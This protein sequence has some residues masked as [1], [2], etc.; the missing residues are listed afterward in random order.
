MEKR[1]I[2]ITGDSGR[3]KSTLASNLSKK[4]NIKHYSTD[5]FLWKK[6]Y[7]EMEDKKLAEDNIGKVYKE[8]EWIVEGGS[9]RMLK[10]SL[11]SADVIVYLGFNNILMQYLVLFRRS[12]KRKNENIKTF[13]ELIRHITYKRFKLGYK[14]GEPTMLETLEPHKHKTIELYSYKEI[15]IF[16]NYF[17]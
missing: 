16:L 17:E 11:E 8:D 6:K 15:E 1:K 13:Y 10:T 12:L 2:I 9:M 3:G 5:D 7:S 4:L 14:K